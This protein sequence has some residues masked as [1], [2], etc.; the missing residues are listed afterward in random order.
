MAETTKKR[1]RR[2]SRR[3]GR[4]TPGGASPA[5]GGWSRSPD[6]PPWGPD[7]LDGG[8]GVREPRRPYPGAPAGALALDEPH[9]ELLNLTG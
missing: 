2:R 6:E 5:R 9:S 7:D 3:A 4:R 8:A 1:V